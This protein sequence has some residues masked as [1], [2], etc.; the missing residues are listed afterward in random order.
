MQSVFDIK[1]EKVWGVEMCLQSGGRKKVLQALSVDCEKKNL[2]ES[3]N[4]Y[5]PTLPSPTFSPILEMDGY[6]M[7]VASL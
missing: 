6:F 1:L 4:P 3:L 5:S 7:L 2:E